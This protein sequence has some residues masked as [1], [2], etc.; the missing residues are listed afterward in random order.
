MGRTLKNTT[1][2]HPYIKFAC[3]K[4]PVLPATG[5][6][7]WFNSDATCHQMSITPHQKDTDNAVACEQSRICFE[8][9]AKGSCGVASQRKRCFWCA[10]YGFWKRPDISA[11]CFGKKQSLQLTKCFSQMPDNYRYL[12]AQKHY[13]KADNI[14]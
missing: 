10:A 6:S 3:S 8:I 1:V 9:T 2:R 12:S 11:V 13:G 4:L 7:H 14:K 5:N